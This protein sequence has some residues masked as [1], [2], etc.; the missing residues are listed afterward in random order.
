MLFQGT[1]TL[2]NI[3][4]SNGSRVQLRKEPAAALI[5]ATVTHVATHRQMEYSALEAEH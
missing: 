3:N 1:K 4:E 2:R 5:N